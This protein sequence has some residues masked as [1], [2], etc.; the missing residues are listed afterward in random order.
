MVLRNI[1]PTYITA[2]CLKYENHETYHHCENCKIYKIAIAF[3]GQ[4]LNLTT[5]LMVQNNLKDNTI[6]SCSPLWLTIPIIRDG[7]AK[8]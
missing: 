2:G 6:F 3:V 7:Q 1:I 8:Q 5:H 4:L